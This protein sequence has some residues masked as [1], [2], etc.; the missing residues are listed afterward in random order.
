MPADGKCQTTRLG[1]GSTFTYELAALFFCA[2]RKHHFPINAII[3][4]IRNGAVSF[5]K[6]TKP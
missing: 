3:K 4:H 2:Q 5:K 1:S 6:Y